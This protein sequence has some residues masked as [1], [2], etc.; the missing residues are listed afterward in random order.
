[1]PPN[2][3]YSD[4]DADSGILSPEFLGALEQLRVAPDNKFYS[5]VNYNLKGN[6]KKLRGYLK[7][8]E[9]KKAFYIQVRQ[10]GGIL[11]EK[12][13]VGSPLMVQA[14]KEF[15]QR[16]DLTRVQEEDPLSLMVSNFLNALIDYI[17]L[18]ID[19]FQQ[20]LAGEEAISPNNYNP[21]QMPGGQP[22]PGRGPAPAPG[23][24]PAP[25]PG[26]GS[27]NPGGRAPA[28][29]PGGGSPN[30]GGRPP[31]R[32][33]GSL[34]EE[35]IRVGRE[36]L[37]ER[38][39][40]RRAKRGGL[41]GS[42]APLDRRVLE[43]FKRKIAAIE[44]RKTLRDAGFDRREKSIRDRYA[45]RVKEFEK[46]EKEIEKHPNP[47]VALERLERKKNTNYAEFRQDLLSL[48]EKR[49]EAYDQDR[50]ELQQIA[51]DAGLDSTFLGA[52]LDAAFDQDGYDY[53]SLSA[54]TEIEK[55]DTATQDMKSR[56]HELLVRLSDDCEDPF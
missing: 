46:Q 33:P 28:P 53:K 20:V 40:R 9:A 38:M 13:I 24:A 14:F 16:F 51:I 55:L 23:G 30:P 26:G 12:D 4:L 27:P 39:R 36:D 25:A 11:R 8:R 35:K 56:L 29:A 3:P 6:E 37:E 47:T 19:A 1:M 18:E 54:P 32:A 17:Q 2:V 49:K 44:R 50:E 5:F 52:F 42:P 15:W 31:R 41:P 48:F 43:R 34:A 7:R 21:T 10:G 45:R 22:A